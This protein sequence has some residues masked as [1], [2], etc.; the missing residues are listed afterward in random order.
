ML[1]NITGAARGEG[2]GDERDDTD[3]VGVRTRSTAQQLLGEALRK[4]GLSKTSFKTVVDAV[5]NV[6]SDYYK[7]NVF[8]SLAEKGQLDAA[9][10]VQIM[11]LISH[12]ESDY[13]AS[14]T[15]TTLLDHQKLS[16]EAFSKLIV[17]GSKLESD[18]Y[19]RQCWAKLRNTNA[20][21]STATIV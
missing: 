1:S 9:I 12:V 20:T 13:Y 15:L 16:D 3:G 5:A 8:N 17:L 18:H 6:E 2:R 7:T 19:A 14:V 10:Q 21:T 11:D 4:P